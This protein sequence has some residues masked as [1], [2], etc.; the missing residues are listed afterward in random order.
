MSHG[1]ITEELAIVDIDKHGV[2]VGYLDQEERFLSPAGL[3]LR[4]KE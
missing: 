1:N 4:R 2:T 3:E